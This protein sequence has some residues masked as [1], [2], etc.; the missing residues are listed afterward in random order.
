MQRVWCAV[1]VL[2]S[3]G[4]WSLVI[5]GSGVCTC[6][7]CAPLSRMKVPL[8]AVPASCWSVYA[9]CVGAMWALLA[10]IEWVGG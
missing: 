1:A 7:G 4:S 2:V 9:F 8:G 3:I 10:C 5:F 6:V